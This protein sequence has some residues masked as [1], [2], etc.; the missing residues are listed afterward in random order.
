[1]TTSRQK[2]TGE[3]IRSETRRVLLGAAAAE[4]ESIGYLKTTVANIAKRAGVTVQTLY[5]AWGSKRELLRAYL[6]N[7]LVGDD[8][9][10]VHF[11][12]EL[13]DAKPLTA[14]DALERIVTIFVEA[15]SRA[16]KAWRIYRDAAP[17]DPEIAEDW[18]QLQ[19]RRLGTLRALVSK[20]PKEAVR[21]GLTEENLADTVWAIASPDS[22]ILL[23]DYGG[24]DPARYQTWLTDTLKAAILDR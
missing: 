3:R 9:P 14:E 10:T 2:L 13:E 20:L 7:Q 19:T 21:R 16:S 5:L 8:D 11:Q 15:A 22:Y 4:F 12:K 18:H 6:S 17:I 1:M 24:Y 23:L